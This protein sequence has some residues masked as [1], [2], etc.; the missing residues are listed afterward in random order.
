MTD[1]SDYAISGILEQEQASGIL[2]PF[3]SKAPG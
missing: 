1:A 2:C 3:F